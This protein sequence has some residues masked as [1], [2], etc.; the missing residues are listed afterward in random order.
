MTDKEIAKIL[1]DY[2]SLCAKIEKFIAHEWPDMKDPEVI[3]VV[4]RN[5]GVFDVD[6][7]YAEGDPETWEHDTVTILFADF[8]NF[9]ENVLSEDDK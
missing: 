5:D 3:H 7:L 9:L 4:L 1:E 6:I 8:E 2:Y